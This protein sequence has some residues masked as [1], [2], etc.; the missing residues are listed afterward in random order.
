MPKIKDPKK[1]GG[2]NISAPQTSKDTPGQ[3]THP[4]FC[5]RHL[6][7]KYDVEDCEADDQRQLIKKFRTLSKMEWS[8]VEQAPKHGLGKETIE[9]TSMKVALPTFITKDVKLWSIRF[10][11]KKPMVGFRA[12]AVFHVV[13]LDH[14]FSVYNHG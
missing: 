12:G 7:P 1:S 13:W 8:A 9:R 2:Q 10:S 6:Q 14:D 3:L 5:L 4:V 11:G